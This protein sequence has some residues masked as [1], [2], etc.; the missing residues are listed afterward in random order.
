MIPQPRKNVSNITSFH[1]S[2]ANRK[3]GQKQPVTGVLQNSFCENICKIHQ[4]TLLMESFLSK[5]LAMAW[6]SIMSLLLVLSCGFFEIP[7]YYQKQHMRFRKTD[8][9]WNK[10]F[11]IVPQNSQENTSVGFSYLIKLQVFSLQLY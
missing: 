2:S 3:K 6:N 11:L 7:G 1:I 10:V 8:V 4:K 9:L 5:L